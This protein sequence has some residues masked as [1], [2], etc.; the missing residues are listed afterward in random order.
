MTLTE[1]LLQRGRDRDPVRACG[2]EAGGEED[3]LNLHNS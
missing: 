1:A 2:R 3:N